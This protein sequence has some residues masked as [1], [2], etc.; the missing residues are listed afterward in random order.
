MK[1]Y[2]NLT[3][4]KKTPQTQPMFGQT[5]VKNSA[6]GY[7]FQ[8]TPQ[9]QLE[10]FIL[11][12]TEGGTYYAT[13]Q[14]LTK[15][16]ATAIVAMIKTDGVKVVQTVVDFAINNRAP[17]ADAGLFV[18][19]LAA[20]FGNQETKNLVYA[21]LTKVVRNAT[22]LFLFLSNIQNLRGWS[23][24]LRK[25]VARFYTDKDIDKLAYQIVK[26]RERAGFTHRDAIRLSHPKT[27]DKARNKLFSYAVGKSTE[28]ESGN[29]TVK[30]FG[31]A[32]DATGTK[33]VNLITKGELTWEMVPTEALN[34]KAV[35]VALLDNMPLTA[36][37]R[38][39]NRFAYNGLTDTNNDVTKKIVAKLTDEAIVSGSGIHPVNV[40]NYMLTYSTG[41]GQK[42]NKTWTANQRI[43]DALG[44]TYEL[45][46]KAVKPT[47]KAILIG[48]DVSG[49]MQAAVGNMAMNASQ[50]GNVLGLTILKSEKNADMV[51]FDT[52]VRA[53]GFGRRTSID[54][55]IRLSPNGGGTDCAQPILYA[56]AHRTK[57]DAIVILTDNESWAGTQHG[58][59]AIKEYRARVNQNVKII[60]VAMVSNPHSN[61]PSNDKNLLRVVGF[62]SSVID[63]INGFL[64]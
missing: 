22:Q 61:L 57:Y 9:E 60:E 21:N 33:L 62:D 63:L 5:M 38:N 15:E 35:L 3:S 17:K 58:A 6:G 11:I 10:R 42:G 24:G 27:S 29:A 40:I 64:K 56:L 50:L 36:L 7:S 23:R 32:K 14:K 55:A 19:A 28:A 20:S 49:S 59:E 34:D 25:A 4:T 1:N 31:K 41:K 52:G 51:W 8:I 18:L 46:L 47:N 12:G 39:L 37:I 45:A 16:N 26:Y 13:E 2:S 44:E 53:A 43:V 54:E 48:V 30:T